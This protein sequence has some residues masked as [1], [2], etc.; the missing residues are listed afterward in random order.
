MLK[1]AFVKKIKMW[2][3]VS[4]TQKARHL[5]LKT[6]NFL[7]HKNLFRKNFNKHKFDIYSL[8]PLL[9]GMYLFTK[10]LHCY[11]ANNKELDKVMNFLDREIKNLEFKYQ[12]KIRRQPIRYNSNNTAT[13]FVI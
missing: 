3:N 9:I 2:D 6:R 4:I 1:N 8:L 7:S 12:G 13:V 5:F 11:Q 10:K